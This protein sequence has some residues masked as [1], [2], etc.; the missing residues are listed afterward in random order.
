M[1]FTCV[2]NFYEFLRSFAE[3]SLTILTGQW[4]IRIHSR[5]HFL[6]RMGSRRGDIGIGSPDFAHT[7]WPAL[8]TVSWKL[9]PGDELI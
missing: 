8:D 5:K 6:V 3:V 9:A 7:P 2:V 4:K 1:V